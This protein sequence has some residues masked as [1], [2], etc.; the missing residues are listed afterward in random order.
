MGRFKRLGATVLLLGAVGLLSAPPASAASHDLI[1]GS[2]TVLDAGSDPIDKALDKANKTS[3]QTTNAVDETTD[4]VTDEVDEA[5]GGNE[6]DRVDTVVRGTTRTVDENVGHLT[7]PNGPVRKAK[8]RIKDAL[9]E[10]VGQAPGNGS[11][12]ADGG[13]DG[14]V[15]GNHPSAAHDGTTDP[16]AIAGVGEDAAGLSSAAAPNESGPS[17]SEAAT[18]SLVEQIERRAEELLRAAAF[19]FVLALVIAAFLLIQNRIDSSDPKLT[20]SPI[21]ADQNYLSFR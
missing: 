1:E 2:Q 3:D 4:G 13:I 12:I 18:P 14:F 9:E 10:V 17:I 20:L 6:G 5:T 8:Q 11:S 7:G 21:D 16:G 19:P 15:T